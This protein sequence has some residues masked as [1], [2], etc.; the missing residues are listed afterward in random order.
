MRKVTILKSDERVLR[1]QR[2]SNHNW[3]QLVHSAT[4][5][6]RRMWVP[7]DGCILRFA[8]STHTHST[9]TQANSLSLT[10]SLHPSPQPFAAFIFMKRFDIH[11][12]HICSIHK[13]YTV[14]CLMFSV[15]WMKFCFSFGS[16]SKLSHCCVVFLHPIRWALRMYAMSLVF[17]VINT[18]SLA[19]PSNKGR[20]NHWALT[21]R[22]YNLT[23]GMNQCWKRV[24]LKQRQKQKDIMMYS[25]YT[26]R[27]PYKMR[28]CGRINIYSLNNDAKKAIRIHF[29]NIIQVF[30]SSSSHLMSYHFCPL[31]FF[32]CFW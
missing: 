32:H 31:I 4:L 26:L 17:Q 28:Q 1:A 3:A 21:C 7:V 18:L 12:V 8:V 22:K 24:N 20:P 23:N 15:Q 2:Q 5:L 29:Q 19:L 6:P 30:S 27:L 11:H 16:S 9:A 25:G 13:S 14:H 10:Q